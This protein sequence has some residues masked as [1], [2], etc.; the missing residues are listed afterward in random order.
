MRE[1]TLLQ[2]LEKLEAIVQ[3]RNAISQYMHLCDDLTHPDTARK[4]GELFSEAAIWQGIGE[5]YQHKL[6]CYEGRDAIV[7]M[8]AAYISE[9][10]HFA[11]NVHYLTAE[12]IN[13]GENNQAV[14]RWKMLQASTFRRGG[15]HLNSAELIIKFIKQG[16][17]WL[18]H[19]FTT[20]NLFS[21]PVDDWHSLA[22]LPVP[23]CN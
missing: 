20:R 13:V 14:G 10:S 21:R 4:I 18:I 3:I 22:D 11:I 16:D 15:S 1:E 12:H 23:D 6:G 19:H 2:R 7:A 9:P 5:L 8:M 17:Q